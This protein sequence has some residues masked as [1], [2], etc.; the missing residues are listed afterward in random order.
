MMLLAMLIL[1]PHSPPSSRA[2]AMR[3][4]R[5]LAQAPGPGGWQ[6]NPSVEAAKQVF[7]AGVAQANVFL[8]KGKARKNVDK[9]RV[10]YE[11]EFA[12]DPDSAD[13]A[14][15][16]FA[17]QAALNAYYMDELN[18]PLLLVAGG[19]IIGGALGADLG[20]VVEKLAGFSK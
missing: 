5:V 15:A 3:H 10:D 11:F 8:G 14:Y 17:L 1:Q 19:T 13:T 7:D 2:C 16:G 6:N 12:K 9:T 4:A 20:D 18:T